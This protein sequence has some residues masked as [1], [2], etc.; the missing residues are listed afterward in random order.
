MLAPSRL[1]F[2]LGNCHRCFAH[3]LNGEQWPD[4]PFPGVFSRLDRCQRAY[5]DGKPT[6][7]IDP[8]LPSGVVRDAAGVTSKPFVHN[9][10]AL[11]IRGTLDALA[12]LDDGSVIVIDY[13]TLVPKHHLG[14]R[15]KWQL[16]AY[17]WALTHPLNGDPLNV[18][19]MGL[20]IVC[21]EEMADTDRGPAQLVSLTW[22]EIP[23]DE[24][25][26][27]DLLEHIA[28][29]AVDP[30]SATSSPYCDWCSLREELVVGL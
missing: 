17:R 24:H 16:A 4:R 7:V 22:V 12:E 2:D 10:V 5:F 18:A 11:T 29:I 26:F 3:Q 15:Y 1:N 14:E 6:T 23:Y 9:G 28:E 30:E 25:W 20:M 8:G 19:S 27:E 13:K 21:P